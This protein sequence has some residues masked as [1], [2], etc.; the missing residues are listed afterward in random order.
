MEWINVVDRYPKLGERVLIFWRCPQGNNYPYVDTA[1]LESKIETAK[2]VEYVWRF[3]SMGWKHEESY[4]N[5]PE[6]KPC[7]VYKWMP[8]TKD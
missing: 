8:I 6:K 3:D 5:T 7:Y 4:L 1:I 2:G